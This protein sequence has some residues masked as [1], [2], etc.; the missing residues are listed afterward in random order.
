V[1]AVLVILGLTAFVDQLKN[2]RKLIAFATTLITIDVLIS[3]AIWANR[4]NSAI[5]DFNKSSDKLGNL[6]GLFGGALSNIAKTIQPSITTG[7]Y[8]VCVGGIVGLV[9]SLLVLKQSTSSPVMT[10]DDF[11]EGN[12]SNISN[13]SNQR[14]IAGI[15]Q[16]PFY[17]SIAVGLVGLFIVIGSNGSAGLSNNISNNLGSDSSATSSS[18]STATNTSSDAFKC[19]KVEN[20]RNV[21]KLNQ[22]SF[23]GDPS[24]SDIFVASQFRFTNNC[25]KSVVG[26]KGSVSFQNVV[27]DSIFN[28]GYTNDQTIPVGG[29]VT[30]SINTGWTFNQF[31]DAHGVL[32]GMDQSKTKAVMTLSKVAFED[33]TSITG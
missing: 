33:G 23:D 27:G 11:E 7:F 18:D 8:M 30:T 29:S 19:F 2:Y 3:Y 4:A 10:Q 28:G 16:I 24:P 20:L 9:A 26:I 6:G 31:E 13:N 17:L 15:P 25:D 14:M 5:N 1:I 22:P 21:I 32:A 12:A